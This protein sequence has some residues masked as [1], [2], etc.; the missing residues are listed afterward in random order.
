MARRVSKVQ[1]FM[2][3]C[4]ISTPLGRLTLAVV[5]CLQGAQTDKVI[6]RQ[7]ASNVSGETS[8][9]GS[10]PSHHRNF[11]NMVPELVVV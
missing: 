10:V 7:L 3:A 5:F 4:V 1:K 6:N 8:V 9:N 11:W 2:A